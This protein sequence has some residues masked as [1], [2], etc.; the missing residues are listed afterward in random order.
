MN[1]RYILYK[2]SNKK[3]TRKEKSDENS[4]KKKKPQR[5]DNGKIECE[6]SIR[7]LR[8]ESYDR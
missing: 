3:M 2:M 1:I 7:D 6:E 8:F 5:K 4:Q